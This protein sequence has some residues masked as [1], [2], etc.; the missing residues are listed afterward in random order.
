MS[1][2]QKF[3]AIGLTAGALAASAGCATRGF[4]RSQVE[5]LRRE[6]EGSATALRSDVDQANSAGERALAQAFR[7]SGQAESASQLALGQ[8]DFREVTRFSVYFAFDSA[9]L[10]ESAWQTLDEA[11]AELERSPQLLAGV[12]GFADPSGSEVYN[13]RLAQRRADAVLRALV[14][15]D[16]TQIPRFSALSCGA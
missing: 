12:Y 2:A 13:L 1:R 5:E 8:V 3:I 16:A 4:V 9:E 11:S 6:T 7:A 15:R 14:A 10:D